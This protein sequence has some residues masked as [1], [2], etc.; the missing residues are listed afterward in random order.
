LAALM[1]RPVAAATLAFPDLPELQGDSGG[2]GAVWFDG[3]DL[4]FVAGRGA[5]HRLPRD[6]APVSEPTELGL[7]IDADGTRA[8]SGGLVVFVDRAGGAMR[9]LEGHWEMAQVPLVG[10]DSL[11]AVAVDSKGRA[12]CVGASRALYVWHEDQWRTHPYS[13]EMRP[14]AA[15]VSPG[16]QLFLVGRKGLVVR[17][18]DG[19]FS[20]LIAPGLRAETIDADWH[21]AWYSVASDRLWVRAGE[22]GLV[23]IDVND[24]LAREFRI[25]VY[26]EEASGAS[27]GDT[28]LDGHSTARGDRLVMAMGRSLYSHEDGRFTYLGNAPATLRDVALISQDREIRVTHERGISRLSTVGENLQPDRPLSEEEQKLLESNLRWRLRVARVRSKK[29][30]FFLPTLR[31]QPGFAIHPDDE[32]WSS[33][34]LEL[35]LGVLI[36][37]IKAKKDTGPTLWLWPEVGYHFDN[38]PR[39]GGHS[40]DLG[41]GLGVGTHIIAVFYRPAAALGRLGDTQGAFGFH[42]SVSAQ[43]LWGVVGIEAGH[44][45]YPGDGRALH[46]YNAGISFNLIPWFWLLVM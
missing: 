32:D 7:A 29:P 42:H 6:G 14:L 9:Y 19:K 12:Y 11:V 22:D 1:A 16:G 17:F 26:D 38:H 5:V 25:P 3:G 41:M 37:P 36:A 4:M 44:Q 13:A 2:A 35:G 21:A 40:A 33:F 27:S 34:D 10:E 15:A 28:I 8:I 39:R 30:L 31:V 18:D 24:R 43:L 23:R 45:V 46:G 20:P